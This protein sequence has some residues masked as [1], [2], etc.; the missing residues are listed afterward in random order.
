[1]PNLQIKA[2][3]VDISQDS[4]RQ[5]DKIFIDTNIWL[6]VAN[7]YPTLS[8]GGNAGKVRV[9]SDFVNACIKANTPLFT[10]SLVLS[11]L[12]HVIEKTNFDIFKQ[13]NNLHLTSKD[14]R[15]NYPQERQSVIQDVEGAWEI[16]NNLS[17]VLETQV[18]S[19]VCSNAINLFKTLPL[20]GYDLFF[21]E[22][23]KMNGINQILTDDA[24]YS[25]IP[26]IQVFTFN[27]NVIETSKNQGNTCSR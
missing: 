15:H 16:V 19:S 21:L 6:M 8:L 20:D 22:N 7:P 2:D 10:L 12:A 5:T 13:K 14:F 1:M 9:Y 26:G 11:E 4:P 25:T 27:R 24:D 3:I 18:D 17:V 23:L